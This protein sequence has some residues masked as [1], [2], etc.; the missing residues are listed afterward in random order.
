MSSASPALAG[1][2]FMTA[3]PR[4]P[5]IAPAYCML[6]CFICDQLCAKLWTVAHQAP[7]SM[8]YPRC[9]YLS[10]QP[11]C[12]PGD[13]SDPGIETRP[14]ELQVDSLPA[15]K[16]LRG[17]QKRSKQSI[18]PVERFESK[19]SPNG[20]L[21]EITYVPSK[22]KAGMEFISTQGGIDGHRMITT[23]TQ[24]KNSFVL[25]IFPTFLPNPEKLKNKRMRKGEGQLQP[26]PSPKQETRRRQ[27]KK[28]KTEFAVQVL[29]WPSFQNTQTSLASSELC[30][31]DQRK[32]I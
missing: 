31:R 5:N 13:L 2:F 7:L 4:K 26:F 6:S 15:Q 9:E 14:P 18:A 16:K 12:S 24:W 11:F 20:P 30:H 27:A 32:E 28:R 3:P 21:I 22:Q 1:G 8:G 29:S 10:G 17:F 25:L 23:S 19:M